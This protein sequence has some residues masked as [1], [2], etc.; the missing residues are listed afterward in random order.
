MESLSSLFFN[1]G[2]ISN[3]LNIR[4]K[5]NIEK[6]VKEMSEIETQNVLTIQDYMLAEDCGNG[7]LLL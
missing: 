4:D 6:C 2:L 5:P 1:K 7:M 3:D